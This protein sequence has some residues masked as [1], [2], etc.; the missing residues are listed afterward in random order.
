MLIDRKTLPEDI[1]S[2]K[3]AIVGMAATQAEFE[4]RY[5]SQI[6]YLQER[7]RL[8]QNELFGR[9]TEKRP[10]P[11]DAK[12]IKLFNEAEELCPEAAAEDEKAADTMQIPAHTRK[13][14]KR[15]PLP[16]DLP[17]VEVIHDLAEQEK[18]CACGAPLCR[19]GQEESE[20]LDIVPAKIQVIRHIRYKFACKNCE[21][22]EDDGPAVKI[23]SAPPQIIAKGMA[24]P[25]FPA[26]IVT[27][28]YADALPLYRQEKIFGR[29]GSDLSRVTMA[30]WMVKTAQTC[31]PIMD[32]LH[33]V[34][35]SGPVINADETPVQVMKEPGRKNTTKSCMWVFRG[36]P[37]LE[38]FKAWID[39]RVD[40]TP[41]KSL[42]GKAF[43]YALSNWPRLIRY[44]E[45]GRLK[46]DNNAAENAIRPFV[47]GRKNLLMA[48][49]PNGQMPRLPFTV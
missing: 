13:K 11:E 20:K 15:K 46:P 34:V 35:L 42:L 44:L 36:G 24:T 40:Q 18:I 28:K 16:R 19:I 14:P 10:L 29:Y 4:Q 25:G 22:V 31:E 6:D 33:K 45:D 43:S 39:K 48:G 12:Q 8:L 27:A 41:P 30:G 17:R 23:A 3:Q 37:I 7:I 32:L 1:D 49:H 26:Y 21:G 9:R 38:E 47:V 2:L 5:R